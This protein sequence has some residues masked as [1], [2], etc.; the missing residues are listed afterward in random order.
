MHGSALSCDEQKSQGSQ[1]K[2]TQENE[3]APNTFAT[4]CAPNPCAKTPLHCTELGQVA[5]GSD[6]PESTSK[7]SSCPD[8]LLTRKTS[9][10]Y[11]NSPWMV[12]ASSGRL[13]AYGR[14][15]N[16]TIWYPLDPLWTGKIASAT[17]TT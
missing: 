4:H 1:R 13:Q 14:S 3:G 6:D 7:A 11:T 8:T 15:R 5:N 10:C 12:C 2:N 9:V 16:V 17:T